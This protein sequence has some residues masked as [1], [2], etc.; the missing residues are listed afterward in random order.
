MKVQFLKE[1][2]YELSE[3]EKSLIIETDEFLLTDDIGNC[4]DFDSRDFFLEKHKGKFS[5][6]TKG[7]ALKFDFLAQTE[8]VVSTVPSLDGSAYSDKQQLESISSDLENHKKV[9]SALEQTVDYLGRKCIVYRNIAVIVSICA[10]LAIL[11]QIFKT[12]IL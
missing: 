3:T 8:V 10:V 7:A 6:H 4:Y 11:I 12:S 5:L 9:C 1:D 2:G